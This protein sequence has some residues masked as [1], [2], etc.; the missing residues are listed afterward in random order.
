LLIQRENLIGESTMK[1]EMEKLYDKALDDVARSHGAAR[2]MA[3]DRRDRI[4]IQLEN[5][6]EEG[7]SD[8]V[9][10]GMYNGKIISEDG[11]LVV[12]FYKRD[13][14]ERLRQYRLDFWELKY[15]RPQYRKTGIV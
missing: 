3:K 6:L 11:E 12:E 10:N 13:G 14:G 15:P 8:L 2:D 4:A 9:T 5:P 7:D 1:T